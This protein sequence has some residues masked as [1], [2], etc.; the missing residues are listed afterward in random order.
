MHCFSQKYANKSPEA[1]SYNFAS[2]FIQDLGPDIPFAQKTC[3]S[4]HMPMAKQS[5]QLIPNTLKPNDY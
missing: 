1:T 2:N 4:Q 3:T 5:Q